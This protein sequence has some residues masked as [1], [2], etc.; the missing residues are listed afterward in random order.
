MPDAKA[1][2]H[3]HNGRR[4]RCYGLIGRTMK[5]TE[6]GMT[7]HYDRRGNVVA[8]SLGSQLFEAA[9]GAQ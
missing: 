2:Y 7:L 4:V 6:Q 3:K 1:D 9:E 8:I 5:E